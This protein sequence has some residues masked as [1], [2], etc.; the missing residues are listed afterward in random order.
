MLQM[1][2]QTQG[3][4]DAVKA[5]CKEL[6]E[7]HPGVDLLVKFEMALDYCARYGDVNLSGQSYNILTPFADKWRE[8]D[9]LRPVHFSF[10]VSI[11]RKQ[12]LNHS[13]NFGFA[14][15]FHGGMPLEPIELEPQEGPHW[16][17]HS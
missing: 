13:G 1:D 8:G 17:F 11:P 9:E 5:K 4:V 2:A 7:E 16:A 14:M 6:D 15:Y 3:Q 10:W 12:T